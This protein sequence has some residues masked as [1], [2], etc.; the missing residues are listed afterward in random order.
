MK[1]IETTIDIDTPLEHLWDIFKDFKSHAEWNPFLTKIQG[2]PNEGESLKIEVT[3]SNGK[4]RYAEPKIEKIILCEDSKE[5]HFITDKKLLFTG[6]HYFIFE[7][8]HPNKTRLVHGEIFS[9]I[10][11]F[12][13]WR[14]MKK[15]FTASFIEMNKALKLRAEKRE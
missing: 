12:I 9:G 11:P 7:A 15:V 14:K 2:S 13:F 5:I 8:Q 1:K 6:R 10:L 4:V 3:L